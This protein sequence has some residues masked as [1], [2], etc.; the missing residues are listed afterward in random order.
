[1]ATGAH[2]PVVGAH[3]IPNSTPSA[4]LR[5][6]NLPVALAFDPHG[7]LYV[8]NAGSSIDPGTTVSVFA[9]GSTTPT[10]TLGGTQDAPLSAPLPSA[11]YP[12]GTPPRAHLH[13]PQGRPFPPHP[14]P[15]PPPQRAVR[16]PPPAPR[17]PGHPQR[18]HLRHNGEQVRPERY[19]HCHS[20]RAG[21]SPRP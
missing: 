8:A 11:Y 12:P 19:P 21:L 2:L 9:P 18:A 14:P 15:P 6:L 7:N 13:A 20:L 4:T 16:P 3:R 17:P 10:R 5:G 1:I